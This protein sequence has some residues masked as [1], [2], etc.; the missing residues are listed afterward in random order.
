MK[1]RLRGR[2]RKPPD[3]TSL[4]DVL[5]IVVF[6][7]LIRAAAAQQAV[8]A[9]TAPK[10]TVPQPPRPPPPPPELA[11]LQQR[12]LAELQADL[13]ARSPVVIRIS[14]TNTI[15]AIEG[16]GKVHRLDTPLL[17]Q[18]VDPTVRLQYLGDRSADLRLCAVAALRLGVP[19]LSRHIVIISP[20]VP[21]DDR[22][23]PINKGL[24]T[25]VARCLVDQRGQAAIVEPAP[26]NKP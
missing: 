14:V 4:F 9:A 23:T 13:A 2:V 24:D 18:N 3:L 17:E 16:D 5:F 19:D 11:A 26:V 1:A 25:D 7:A 12:A 21:R 20:A 8:A 22:L 15:E 10:L 6:V